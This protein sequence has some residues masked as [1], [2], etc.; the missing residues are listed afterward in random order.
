MA[1]YSTCLLICR[2]LIFIFIDILICLLVSFYV[3][4]G[5]VF[6]EPFFIALSRLA[7]VGMKS[8]AWRYCASSGLVVWSR[9]LFARTSDFVVSKGNS[10]I[11]V[12]LFLVPFIIFCPFFLTDISYFS[13]VMVHLSS[14]KTP[15]DISGAIFIFGEI[16]IWLACFLGT[17]IWSVSICDDSIVLQYVSHAVM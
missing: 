3:I 13:S 5:Q 4:T 6:R 10:H 9:M 2:F 17:G 7:D 1:D 11:P 12:C 15:N 14:H 8:D 16:I